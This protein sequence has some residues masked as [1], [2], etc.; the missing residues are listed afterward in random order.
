LRSGNE[1]LR[2]RDDGVAVST[3]DVKF[4]TF[5]VGPGERDMSLETEPVPKSAA[6]KTVA[7][8][9]ARQSVEAG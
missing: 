2:K 8:K 3:W 1:H 9:R 6:R 4:F 7:R 5:S